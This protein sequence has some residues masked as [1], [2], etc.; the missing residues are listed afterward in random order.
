MLKLMASPG[1][2][3]R[4]EVVPWP[5]MVTAAYCL[6]LHLDPSMIVIHIPEGPNGREQLAAFLRSVANEAGLLAMVLDPKPVRKR[7]PDL[8]E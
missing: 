1:P 8:P 3:A 4:A 5:G 6:R 2:D 7:P